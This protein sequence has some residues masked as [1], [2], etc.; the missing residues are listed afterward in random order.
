MTTYRKLA[1]TSNRK[2]IPQP[3]C[4]ATQKE[5]RIRTNVSVNMPN[6]K[7]RGRIAIAATMFSMP[8]VLLLSENTP[9]RIAAKMQSKLRTMAALRRGLSEP[10]KIAPAAVTTADAITTT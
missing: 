4:A 2:I 6:R 9:E 1:S 3:S 10:K 8:F 5:W 7:G